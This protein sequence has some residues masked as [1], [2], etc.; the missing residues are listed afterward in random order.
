[1]V[2]LLPQN[3]HSSQRTSLVPRGTYHPRKHAPESTATAPAAPIAAP[4]APKAPIFRPFEPKQRAPTLFS[5]NSLQNR[6]PKR[7]KR[8]T[9]G[10]EINLSLRTA[11]H[12]RR[13]TSA[14]PSTHPGAGTTTFS[15]RPGATQPTP[16][17]SASKITSDR[18]LSAQ[19]EALGS[20]ERGRNDFVVEVPYPVPV[21]PKSPASQPRRCRSPPPT[22]EKHRF[23]GVPARCS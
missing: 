4:A 1:M 22:H 21:P 12:H 19:K 11:G 10:R 3:T 23:F 6:A 15:R 7:S 18:L 20:R 5:S 2:P 14:A 17:A 8:R 16:P 9:T 13:P